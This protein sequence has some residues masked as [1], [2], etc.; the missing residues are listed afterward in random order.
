[1]CR[2]EINDHPSA[3]EGYSATTEL[4]APCSVFY[5]AM[6]HRLGGS[7]TTMVI[8]WKR[9]ISL[10]N[11]PGARNLSY[12]I[13]TGAMDLVRRREMSKQGL[14]FVLIP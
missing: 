3:K 4:T 10:A 9:A 8:L 2:I 6:K 7:D 12:R 13:R 11:V 14:I 5:M 1:M